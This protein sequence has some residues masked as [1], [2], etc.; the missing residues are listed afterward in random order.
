MKNMEREVKECIEK[1][2][3]EGR[4]KMIEPKE[5]KERDDYY[6]EKCKYVEP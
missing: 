6:C 3:K 2:N 5:N 1:R 4:R